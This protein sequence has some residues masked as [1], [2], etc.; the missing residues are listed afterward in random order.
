MSYQTT[1]STELK[2]VNQILA[3]VGQAPV[4]T[5]ETEDTIVISKVDRIYRIY[6]WYHFDY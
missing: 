1:G 2:A 6:F 3:S 4:T 5:L